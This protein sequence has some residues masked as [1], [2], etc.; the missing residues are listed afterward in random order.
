MQ[1][2]QYEI[3]PET[4]RV[5]LVQKSYIDIEREQVASRLEEA[6]RLEAELVERKVNEYKELLLEDEEVVAARKRVEDCKSGL[7][8]Y[9]QTAERLQFETITEGPSSAD[10]FGTSVPVHVV[11]QDRTP[12]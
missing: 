7:S 5:A 4:G 10:P 11:G 8:L 3:N 12:Y 2:P 1:E 9:D 6:E